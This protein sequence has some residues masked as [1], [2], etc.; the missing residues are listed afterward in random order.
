MR[1]CGKGSVLGMRAQTR[2][3]GCQADTELSCHSASQALLAR[4]VWGGQLA[5]E[6]CLWPDGGRL[7]LILLGLLATGLSA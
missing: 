4:A 6:A 2:V 3:S 7:P 1:A 5:A